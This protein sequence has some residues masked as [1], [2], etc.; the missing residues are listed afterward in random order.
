MSQWRELCDEFGDE[1]HRL[2]SRGDAY[3]RDPRCV[4]CG[5]AT[6]VSFRCTDCCYGHMLCSSCIC[7]RHNRLPF[8]QIEVRS[9]VPKCA[10]FY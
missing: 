9:F 6:H 10:D 8:H 1:L 4:H 7:V 2:N 3:L 5:T